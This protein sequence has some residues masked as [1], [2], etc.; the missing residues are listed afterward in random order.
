MVSNSIVFFDGN[1]S[2]DSRLFYKEIS[3][4]AG[5]IRRSK[6]NHNNNNINNNRGADQK[7][8]HRH[9]YAQTGG[10]SSSSS[11]PKLEITQSTK[12]PI[13]TYYTPTTLGSTTTSTTSTTTTTE[14]SY[15][16]NNYNNN[17]SNNDDSKR[18]KQ[19]GLGLQCPKINHDPIHRRFRRYLQGF[20]QLALLLQPPRGSGIRRGTQPAQAQR[21][22]GL[23]AQDDPGHAH[24]RCSTSNFRFE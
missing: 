4:I 5:D 18:K 3:L 23:P 9:N 1:D 2:H 16:N 10:S 17:Y 13:S 12:R 20:T 8:R 15:Y 19:Y 22:F 11:S 6:E 14:R 21:L 24:A 7:P